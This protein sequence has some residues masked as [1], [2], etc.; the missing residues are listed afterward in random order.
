[1]ACVNAALAVGIKIGTWLIEHDQEWI[2]IKCARKCNPL[3][4][5]ARDG[6]SEFTNLRSVS[7]R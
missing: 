7:G 4:L 3:A 5:S 2:S 6:H 1:M